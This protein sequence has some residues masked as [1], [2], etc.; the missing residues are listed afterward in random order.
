MGLAHYRRRLKL[1]D[2][3]VAYIKEQ[4]IDLVVGHPQF[5]ME[6]IREFFARYI[7]SRDWTLLK[8][9]VCGYDRDMR[10]VLHV[11]KKVTFIFRVMWLYGSG[12]GLIGIA[13]L[14]LM[15]LHR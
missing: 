15:W 3:S 6:T 12:N 4:G 11:M 10:T 7:Y 13:G 2:G 14:L 9:V 8:E 1:D 5:E